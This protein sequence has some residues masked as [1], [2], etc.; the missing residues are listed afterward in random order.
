MRELLDFKISPKE[1]S[2]VLNKA[3]V[4]A[5][6]KQLKTRR[7][8]FAKSEWPLL[9]PLCQPERFDIT[10]L[11]KLLRQD[12]I[13]TLPNPRTDW[14]KLPSNDDLS[15]E[16]DIVRIHYYR[17]FFSHPDENMEIR[18]PEFPD[19]WNQVKDAI[20]GILRYFT[21]NGSPIIRETWER[22]IDELRTC[23]LEGGGSSFLD[24]VTQG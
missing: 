8:L 19:Y 13:C 9:Y 21:P 11:V 12:V 7:I 20:L 6:L 5:R 23:P 4:L 24:D 1:L 22:E 15:L 3:P 10:L 14:E 17:N 2:E 16:A 18:E